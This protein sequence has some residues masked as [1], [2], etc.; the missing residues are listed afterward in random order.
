MAAAAFS[1]DAVH[2]SLNR[3]PKAGGGLKS[4]NPLQQASYFDI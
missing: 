2:R 3:L 4:P 1:S